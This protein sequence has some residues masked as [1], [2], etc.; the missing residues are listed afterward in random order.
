MLFSTRSKN[1]VLWGATFFTVLTG[2]V[3]PSPGQAKPASDP[4][5]EFQQGELSLKSNRLEE[6]E[7]HFR[8]VLTADPQLA[9][10][11]A[12]LGVVYMR[13]KQWK[14][15]LGMLEKAEHLAPDISG[16]RLNIG[17]VHYRQNAFRSAI[18]EFESVVNES[19]SFQARYLLGLCYFLTEHYAEATTTLEPLWSQASDQLN[20]LYALGIAA[21]KS[22]HSDI[23]Q[24]ALG[25]LLEIGQNSAELHLLMGKA[26]LNREEYDDAVKELEAAAT[27]DP[28]LPFVHFNLGVAYYRKQNLERAEQEFLKDIVVEPDVA[29]SYDQLGLVNFL[30]QKDRDAAKN[31]R[32][33]L[34]LNPQL[35]SAHYTLARVYQRTGKNAEA[36]AEIDAADKADPSNYTIHYLRGQILRQLGRVEEAKAEMQATTRMMN[37][38]REKRQKELYGGALP[39]PEIMQEP[40]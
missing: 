29:Y 6:A 9:G 32:Q 19:N 5:Q 12:N 3:L 1:F 27:A 21:G 7:Q 24:R 25:R 8:A 40:K 2:T 28:K 10:A 39:S 23:E 36:L 33:A 31:L 13:R 15:A 37:K 17:L 34:R 4:Q 16:I 38:P 20:Y 35:A 22:E 11:Y 26:H 14:Q 30:Q 18:P